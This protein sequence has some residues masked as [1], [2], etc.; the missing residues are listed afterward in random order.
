MNREQEI[1]SLQTRL[2]ELDSVS[3]NVWVETQEILHRLNELNAYI[4]ENEEVT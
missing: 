3:F 2:R 1:E 4:P